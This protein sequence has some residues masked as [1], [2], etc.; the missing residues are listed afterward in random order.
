M[1]DREVYYH[2]FLSVFAE[3]N[4]EYGASGTM[5]SYAFRVS[6]GFGKLINFSLPNTVHRERP[7]IIDVHLLYVDRTDPIYQF[8]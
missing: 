2:V 6:G 1:S 4:K 3:W 8:I 5:E 7:A